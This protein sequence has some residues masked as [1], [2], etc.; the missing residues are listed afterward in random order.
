MKKQFAI[1]SGAENQLANSIYITVYSTHPSCIRVVSSS[2]TIS[3]ENLVTSSDAITDIP[4]HG[5][6]QYLKI[7]MMNFN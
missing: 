6:Y 4:L 7:S 5:S 2:R 3:R 1:I